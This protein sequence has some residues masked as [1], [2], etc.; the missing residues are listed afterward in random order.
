VQEFPNFNADDLGDIIRVKT[1]FIQ[2]V[3]LNVDPDKIG[4]PAQQFFELLF[5]DLLGIHHQ[6]PWRPRRP[7]ISH[8]INIDVKRVAFFSPE[9]HF[10]RISCKRTVS[11]M[12]AGVFPD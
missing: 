2:I 1:I 12:G 4:K 9:H 8:R 6:G 3:L 7:L 11:F 10:V 5:L